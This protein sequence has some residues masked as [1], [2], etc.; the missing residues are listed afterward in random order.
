MRRIGP[1]PAFRKGLLSLGA[2]AALLIA[3]GC[4]TR[5]DAA[6]YREYSNF[7]TASGRFRLEAAPADAPYGPA[8]LIRNFE[9]VAF[10]PEAQLAAFYAQRPGLRRLSKWRGGFT[11]AVVGDGARTSDLDEVER[12][13][14]TLT[15]RTGLRIREDYRRPD[16]TVFMLTDRARRS[17][18]ATGE[19]QDWYDGSLFRD[20]VETLNPPCFALFD[21]SSPNGGLIRSG[22]VFIKAEIEQPLRDA[23]LV[24]ELTQSMGLI[25]DHDDVRPSI[26]NDDQEFIA[27]TRHDEAL[28]EILYDPRLQAGMTRAQA[29]PIVRQIVAE[30]GARL[31][32]ASA[33]PVR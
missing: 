8:D 1:F 13:M 32:T 7:M 30:K 16:L 21:A 20:W 33:G 17:V 5:D 26:F 2:L 3:P 29:A 9:K 28:L 31:S 18:A 24:E 14:A 15:R 25:F 27:L 10:E 6:A 19:A 22:A 11:Y 4:A 12:I 23:C